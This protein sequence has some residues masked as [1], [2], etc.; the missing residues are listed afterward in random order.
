MWTCSKCG[1]IFEKEN[2]PHSCHK[3]PLEVHFKNKDKAKEIFD[4]LVE[5]VNV[6]VGKC[7]IISIPCCVHLFGNY[8]FLAALP[9]KD[10][11]EIRFALDRR[12]D[13]PRLKQAVPLSTKIFKNCFDITKTEEINNELI[14]W[15][16][17]SYNLKNL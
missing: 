10:K 3:T 6:K 16:N 2:Q 14:K 8:D 11:L 9:K 13:S 1:R 4:Y 17:E 15:L 7:K 5:Q 12:L